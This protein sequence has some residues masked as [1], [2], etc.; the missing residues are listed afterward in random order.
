MFLVTE[1]PHF[2]V[3]DEEYRVVHYE[4]VSSSGVIALTMNAQVYSRVEDIGMSNVC[5][6]K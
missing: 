1:F 3:R 5:M 4:R 6:V 2:H